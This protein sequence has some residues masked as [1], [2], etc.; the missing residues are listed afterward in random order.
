M[1]A[2]FPIRERVKSNIMES[3]KVKKLISRRGEA[4]IELVEFR[5]H[6]IPSTAPIRPTITQS[7]LEIRNLQQA[8]FRTADGNIF[9]LPP[10]SRG[11]SHE[12]KMN[13]GSI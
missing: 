1:S 12:R 8:E 2:R 3:F 11:G 6:N 5:S 7:L 9:V 10:T 4:S 13:L